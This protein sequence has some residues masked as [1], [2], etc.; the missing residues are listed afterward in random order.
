M[1]SPRFL[2]TCLLSSFAA[3]LGAPAIAQIT[4]DQTLGTEES[5][6]TP[7]VEVRGG[8]TDL[9]EGGAARGPN[10][11]HS[12]SDFN[13]LDS[14][15]VYFANPQ[16]VE[17]ILSRVTGSNLSNIFGTLG[18][19][20]TADLFLL[21]PNGIVFGEMAN[22]DVEGSFYVTTGDAIELGDEVFSAREPEGSRLLRVSPSVLLESYLTANSG[23]IEN[24]GQL[25][26]SGNI[27][28]AA[29][30]LNLQR[31][32][33]AGGDLTLLSLGE[34][35][36]R[37]TVETPFV[38]FA[39]GN[40]LVQG[41]QQVDIV[42]LSHADSGLYSYGDMVLRS[43]NPVGGDAHYWSGG[44]F[45][46]ETLDNRAGNLRSPIDPIIRSFGNVVIGEYEGSS[47]HILAGG[48]VNIGTAEIDAPDEGN[49]G[50]DFLQETVILSDGTILKV[51]GRAQPTLDIRAGV[52]PEVIGP[53]PLTF[54]TG[55]DSQDSFDGQG[56]F[57]TEI[58]TSADITI[59]D[60]YIDAEN[61][62]MLLTNRYQP[63]PNIQG[64]SISVEGEGIYGDGLD[65]RGFD[66]QGGAIYL[67][68][69]QDIEV[70]NNFISTSGSDE[71][72]D[73]VML[74]KDTVRLNEA[75]LGTSLLGTGEGGEIRINAANGVL[76]DRS[77]IS[78]DIFEGEG[79]AGA[80]SID[81]SSLVL[82]NGSS[83]GS[84]IF[85][86]GKGTAGAIS[87]DASNLVLLNGSSVDSDIS[88]EGIAGTIS[89]EVDNLSV[90]NSQIISSVFGEGAA[91]NINVDATNVALIGEISDSNRN[92][93]SP[94]GILSQVERDGGRG[95]SGSIAI[96]TETLTVRD[97]SKVQVAN[98]G[99]GNAGTLLISARDIDVFD[100][101][102]ANNFF[103][104]GIF[105]GLALDP[106]SE[107][108]PDGDGGSLVIDAERL[109]LRNGAD[110]SADNRGIG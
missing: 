74:A 16:G 82:L 59:S 17:S 41:N 9:V 47:L 71:V 94:G 83:V 51:D 91:G 70:V 8:L 13:V 72:G 46:V 26:A 15:R 85:E 96:N 28:I 60:G 31:Q 77:R 109:S 22:L 93:T 32:V 57:E 43:A 2:L 10:L 78:S 12:F 79:I 40:L 44:S 87:I 6:V 63:N 68:S 80:V 20:G 90:V 62:L 7:N 45:R 103:S 54:Q 34:V 24:Q 49:I 84:S 69:R 95:Q 48:S 76:L 23:D 110:I 30:G 42:A 86:E 39:G 18:V 104:T 75:R 88:E 100:S 25:A 102:D 36:I 64:G 107:T 52:M 33:I 66:R 92:V 106:R 89:I 55:F 97:G 35:Q 61:G 56:L 65:A 5:I 1:R 108:S 98:F 4:P 11:F 19:D 73:I 37:D 38:G 81:T 27:T 21:N 105:A 67:D 3:L 50:I 99:E 14:Q 29:N 53:P 58:P 101:E